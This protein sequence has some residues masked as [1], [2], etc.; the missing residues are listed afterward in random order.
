[1]SVTDVCSGYNTFSGLAMNTIVTNSGDHKNETGHEST[2]LVKVCT[3]SEEVIQALDI[4][5][6]IDVK[7]QRGSFNAKME[8]ANLLN[9]N[10]TTVVILISATKISETQHVKNAR[11]NF[12]YFEAI[13]LYKAG[14]DSYVSNISKGGAYY[15]A[16]IFTANDKTTYYNIIAQANASFKPGLSSIDAD[17]SA[18]IGKIQTNTNLGY[19]VEHIGLG[20]SSTPMP[21]PDGIIEFA[22][23]FN[24]L[25][26]DGPEVVS[27]E[28][29][30]YSAAEGC[31][32]FTQIDKYRAQY[33][34]NKNNN[35]S[36]TPLLSDIRFLTD[37]N[38]RIIEKVNKIYE[39][40]NMATIDPL[41][42]IV[43]ND[44]SDNIKAIDDWVSAVTADPTRSD[45]LYPTLKEI[46]NSIPIPIYTILPG[47]IVGQNT[48][49]SFKNEVTIDMIPK[50]VSP[51]S[52]LINGNDHDMCQ[53]N[54]TY[55]FKDGVTPE[56]EMKN[57]TYV[58]RNCPI[59][60]L[61]HEN[62]T[63]VRIRYNDQGI[64]NV[65]FVA[66][67][68][69]I[70]P[71]P[72]ANS[73]SGKYEVTSSIPENSRFIGWGGTVGG[74]INSLYVIYVKFDKCVWN[75]SLLTQM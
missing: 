15:V 71:Y 37:K 28:T 23:N 45:I 50:G 36:G 13:D 73:N 24:S 40:Y 66:S 60:Y 4:K 49:T 58:Q 29:T 14:G 31:P 41:L 48:G 64:S 72:A 25:A 46:H 47:P 53:I 20:F 38:K 10:T 19:S 54:T 1:M 55:A 30:S 22:R 42:T 43:S 75:N 17:F 59:I 2:L 62:I 44:L 3:T 27:F 21:G 69:T 65:A 16:Y 7:A 51:K 18:E 39:N 32:D 63:E 70:G 68:R 11:L 52:I 26:L 34:Y 35:I 9:I 56:Y 5:F 74:I 61:E 67:G 6:D 57:G 33:T 12:D 8:F